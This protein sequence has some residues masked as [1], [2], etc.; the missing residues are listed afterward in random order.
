MLKHDKKAISTPNTTSKGYRKY[1]KSG[2]DFFN[3]NPNS[4]INVSVIVVGRHD[5]D[6]YKEST[7]KLKDTGAFL[8]YSK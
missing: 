8:I 7:E 3:Y 2:I 5:Y 4:L 6:C 1:S